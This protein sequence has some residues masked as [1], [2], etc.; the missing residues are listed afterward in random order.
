[1]IKIYENDEQKL[2]YFKGSTEGR[3]DNNFTCKIITI[4]KINIITKK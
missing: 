3:I 2:I 1:M 4:E